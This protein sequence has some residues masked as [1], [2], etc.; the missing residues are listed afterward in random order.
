M[1]ALVA[2][3]YWSSASAEVFVCEGIVWLADWDDAAT[4]VVFARGLSPRELAV[5][6]G[7]RPGA[8]VE[9]TG[10]E[11]HRLL[12]RPQASG[13]NVVR[14]GS[15]GAWSHAVLHLTDFAGN[16]LAVRA[17]HDGVEVIEYLPMHWHPPDQFAYLRDGQ[18]VCA[19]G[20]GEEAHRW[21]RD[22]DHLLPVLVEGGVLEP[23]GRTH[24][25]P[26]QGAAAVDARLTL[27]VLQDH[28]GL[29]MPRENMMQEPLPAYSVRGC[30]DLGPDPDY[31]TVRAWA[32]ELGHPTD[33]GRG[34]HVPT[35][36]REAY[37]KATGA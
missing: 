28:F 6:M 7:G 23:A 5:R 9:M 17:S 2:T 37:S 35:P 11:V 12:H 19:F 4:G 8:E 29:C 21:G 34:G 20:T 22:P 31:A 18:T 36:I 32:A 24:P 15:C 33:W 26:S 16:D 1:S 27:K 25:A 13:S 3:V 30:L 10:G 14:I